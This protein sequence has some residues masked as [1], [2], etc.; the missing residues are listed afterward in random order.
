MAKRR[1]QFGLLPF[2]FVTIRCLQVSYY[3]YNFPA[4]PC[5]AD[6]FTRPNKVCKVSSVPVK[7]RRP[8]KAL[9]AG[10]TASTYPPPPPPPSPYQIVSLHKICIIYGE[11][12][13]STLSRPFPTLPPSPPRQGDSICKNFLI[14]S[15]VYS[16]S[17]L[18]GHFWPQVNHFN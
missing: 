6:I 13:S 3:Y 2:P 16:N 9:K 11:C 7:L 10:Q 15:S 12:L 8:R 1:Y 14:F 17:I 5:D 4:C 18:Q